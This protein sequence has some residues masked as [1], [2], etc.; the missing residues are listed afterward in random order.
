MT[1]IHD[2]NFSGNVEQVLVYPFCVDKH[3]VHILGNI[4]FLFFQHLYDLTEKNWNQFG[5][6]LSSLISPVSALTM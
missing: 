3:L 2:N 1:M 6:K 5:L 4:S